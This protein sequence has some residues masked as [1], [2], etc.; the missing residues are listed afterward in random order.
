MKNAN[1]SVLGIGACLL[2]LLLA[3]AGCSSDSSSD[4]PTDNSGLPADPGAGNLAGIVYGT[5]SGQPLAGVAV[6]ANGISTTTDSAGVFRLNGV[7]TGTMGVAISGNAVYARTAAVNTATAR[8]VRLDA[9]ETSSGFNLAFY[10]EIARG[11]EPTERNIYPTHRWTNSTPL[12]VYIDTDASATLDGV[13]SQNQIDTVRSVITQIIPVFTG[14]FYTSVTIKTQ[15]FTRLDFNRDIPDNAFVIS[16][17]DSLMS[18]GAFGITE[19]DPDFVSPAISSINKAIVRLVDQSSFYTRGGITFEE[20]LAHESGHGF[21]FRHT[22]N[23][24]PSVML[25]LGAFGGLYSDADRLHMAIVYKRPSGNADI[26]NDPIPG[27]K[28]VGE[29]IGRQIFIDRR[30]N[31][32]LAPELLARVRALPSKIPRE[33]LEQVSTH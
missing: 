32:P 7:G 17:D 31:F 20:V 15:P 28:M 1:R 2:L 33:L 4:N 27:A 12:T 25:R 23:I 11:N 26:D 18:L 16:F 10:R 8:S 30:A 9:I 21:G 6:S 14:N 19:T 13:I 3:L 29:Q 22:S 5:V 24:L